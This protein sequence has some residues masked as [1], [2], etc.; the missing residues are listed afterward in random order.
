MRDIKQLSKNGYLKSSALK[1]GEIA[2]AAK[3]PLSTK[4]VVGYLIGL[5]LAAIVVFTGIYFH[6]KQEAAFEEQKKTFEEILKE[7]EAVSAP[8]I[9]ED[10]IKPKKDKINEI[11]A[12]IGL[13]SYYVKA[14]L[15]L[16]LFGIVI[17][18]AIGKYFTDVVIVGP[19][20]HISRVSQRIAEGDLSQEV[21]I[22]S[23]DEIGTLAQ[24]FNYM[25]RK[26]REIISYQ[27]EQIN[28]LLD[29]VNAA[30]AGNLTKQVTI[31][32]NDEFGNLSSA[33]NTMTKNLSRL[34]KQVEEASAKISVAASN[35]LSATEQQAAGI[36]EQAT[37]IS[38]I[39]SSLQELTA[40]SRQIAEGSHQVASSA[41]Q[42]TKTA[43]EG[44]KIVQESINAIKR[45]EQTVQ[46][47]AKKIKGLG[48]SSKKIGKVITAIQ[49]IAEQTNLLA[50][51]AAIEAA[52][53][54]EAGRGFAV[55]ADEIRKLAE[56]SSNSAEEINNL[57]TSIQTETNSTVMAME[58]GLRSVEE[59]VVLITRTGDAFEEII[60]TV[61]YSA[62]I[63]REISLST[64][65]Q[66]KGNEQLSFAMTNLS[67]VIKQTEASARQNAQASNELN[68]LSRQLKLAIS[69]II[70]PK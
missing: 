31:D 48:E 14:V 2:S 8:D 42:A 34:V 27:K 30:A 11:S 41:L 63:S 22:K 10:I 59:G 24:S 57:I 17:F 1:I 6:Y 12:K 55:V 50:L 21:E 69:E 56:R 19:I 44:G 67:Q 26:L 3:V 53:A 29:V 36:T 23:Q 58:D 66:T 9:I 45:I 18:T 33:F 40:S 62:N 13:Y 5:A 52:R 37:Q 54:G 32:T 65:Q 4:V 68:E 28:K 61:E 35:I 47:T 60:K 15:I 64:E 46:A 7:Q 39:A 38:Q 70:L 51:N 25:T 49:E 16:M 43:K 20:T